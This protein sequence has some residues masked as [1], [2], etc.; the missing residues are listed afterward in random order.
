MFALRRRSS[1]AEF[2]IGLSSNCAAVCTAVLAVQRASV[3]RP[4]AAYA[5]RLDRACSQLPLRER[6]TNIM[7]PTEDSRKGGV[8][9]RQF[10]GA[11]VAGRTTIFVCS[12]FS[13][14]VAVKAGARLLVSGF[15]CSFGFRKLFSRSRGDLE[16]RS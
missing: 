1:E 16:S 2:A 4:D 9:D 5:S 6:D 11:A 8:G 13:R 10:A 3:T 15:T 7:G 12:F 14:G